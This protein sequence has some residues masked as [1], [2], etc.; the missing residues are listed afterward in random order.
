MKK[1]RERYF[2][3]E[4]LKLMP[5]LRVLNLRDSEAPDFLCDVAG[6]PTAIE[7]TRFFFPVSEGLPPQAAEAYHSRLGAELTEEHLKSTI[8]P[9]HVSVCL[10]RDEALFKSRS[11]TGL[12]EELFA[13]VSNSVP[14]PGPC[15]EF[16]S[17]S[18]PES[19][20]EKGVDS[21]RIMNANLPS[22]LWSFGYAS[23]I[24]E[25]SSSIVQ[26]ILNEN[27]PRVPRYRKKA[28]N[29]WLLILS[30]TDGL[31]SIV[32]FD[33]DVLTHQYSTDFDRLFL[34]RTVSRSAHELKKL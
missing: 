4:F 15:R 22:P 31:H 14:P 13:F 5:E 34:F 10:Y 9:V 32:N 16:D 28:P 17:E 2:L 29:L 1:D 30:G 18:L 8:P 6:I 12:R 24:P 25:S 21:I 11:R 7:V 19:L 20:C 33:R 23:F 3:Q 27:A 26:G